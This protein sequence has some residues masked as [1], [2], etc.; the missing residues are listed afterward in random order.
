MG[1]VNLKK[2]QSGVLS[3]CWLQLLLEVQVC[4][5]G[6]LPSGNKIIATILSAAHRSTIN[7]P[8]WG[9]L[10]QSPSAFPSIS[11]APPSCFLFLCRPVCAPLQASLQPVC[12]PLLSPVPVALASITCFLLLTLDWPWSIFLLFL[13]VTQLTELQ[14]Q[15]LILSLFLH[16]GIVDAGVHACWQFGC[17]SQIWPYGGKGIGCPKPG[18]YCFDCLLNKSIHFLS[19]SSLSLES[20]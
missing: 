10:S 20:Y 1:E 14:I 12:P 7:F 5:L 4:I 15:Q 2:K 3:L 19:D 9:S 6:R 16:L 11:V 17:F 8:S 13:K 18:L